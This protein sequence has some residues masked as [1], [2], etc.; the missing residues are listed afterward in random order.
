MSDRVTSYLSLLQVVKSFLNERQEK[1][2]TN[3]ERYVQ[4]AI[5]GYSDMQLFEMNTVEVAYLAVNKDTMTAAL[6]VDFMTMTKIG[7]EIAGKMWTLTVNNDLILPRPESICPVP[8][9]QVDQ[10]VSVDGGYFFA[11]HYRYGRYTNTLYGVGGGFNIAYYRIDMNNRVIYFH[12]QVPNNEVILEYKSSG[13]KVGGAMIPRDA[14]PALKAYLHWKTAEY[15]TRL[16][17]NEKVRK[18]NLYDKELYKLKALECSFTINEYL[19][20]LYSTMSQA[21]KR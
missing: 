12:G 1:N 14:V 3:L 15:D 10:N 11:P 19:D 9:E 17:M 16:P 8:I 6:P 4:M 2:L 5:E 18:E 7:V 13:V 21:P 20:N